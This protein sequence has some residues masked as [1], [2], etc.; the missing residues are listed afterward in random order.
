M[1]YQANAWKHVP[2]G[3]CTTIATPKGKGSLQAMKG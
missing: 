2:K 1:D 3:T